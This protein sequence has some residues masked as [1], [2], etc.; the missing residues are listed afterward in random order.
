LTYSSKFF[1]M[2]DCTIPF[3]G[4]FLLFGFLFRFCDT[5]FYIVY[6]S[7]KFWWCHLRRSPRIWT[8]PCSG[9][10][11]LVTSRLFLF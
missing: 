5:S 10:P 3:F 9:S 6:S 1:T 4:L 11:T 2:Y 7:I 8:D